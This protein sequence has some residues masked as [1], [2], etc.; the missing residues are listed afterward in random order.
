MQRGDPCALDVWRDSVFGA[1]GDADVAEGAH[2]P[3]YGIRSSGQQ[4]F[5]TRSSLDWLAQAVRD[6]LNAE[7]SS[8]QSEAPQHRLKRTSSSACEYEERARCMLSLLRHVEP[9]LVASLED[10]VSAG[11]EH[12]DGV[13]GVVPD[14]ASRSPVEVVLG[15]GAEA[16]VQAEGVSRVKDPVGEVVAVSCLILDGIAGKGPGHRHQ[17]V[18]V[19]VV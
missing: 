5:P 10:D 9:P 18:D 6:A 17:E 8:Q 19:L 12:V 11:V 3:T 7:G 1:L 2:D 16:R 13:S 4:D 14:G 15:I